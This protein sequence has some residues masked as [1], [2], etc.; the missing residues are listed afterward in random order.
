MLQY[1]GYCPHSL[2]QNEAYL[3]GVVPIEEMSNK[4]IIIFGAGAYGVYAANLLRD[5]GI[6]VKAFCSNYKT[7][8]GKLHHSI[9]IIKP[10]DAFKM[11]NAYFIVAAISGCET[12]QRQLLSKN[13]YDFSVFFL[14]S[15]GNISNPI[16]AETIR[17]SLIPTVMSK[18]FTEGRNPSQVS[19][20]DYHKAVSRQFKS[21]RYSEIV[22]NKYVSDFLQIHNPKKMLDIG[23]GNGLSSYV[24]CYLCENLDTAWICLS[25]GEKHMEE[26]FIDATGSKFP[27]RKYF[28]QIENPNFLLDEKF[29]LIIFTEIMEHL[30]C[31]PVPTVK[32]IAE[33]LSDDGYI[34]F[35]TPEEHLNNYD[36]YVEMPNYESLEK[37]ERMTEFGAPV[38]MDLSFPHTYIYS[39]Q[40]LEEIFGEAGLE[41]KFYHQ[42]APFQ[43]QHIILGKI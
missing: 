27:V 13:I 8:W 33:M 6:F 7:E 40:E 18:F 15:I 3:L 16:L 43:P 5:H 20:M 26:G 29:D 21:L 24:L 25:N 34:I 9:E 42:T 31:N 14:D 4:N 1:L 22:L 36:S 2:N 41:I 39:K 10:T 28:G 35:S 38:Y 17:Y 30:Q 37:Y 32:K 19:I 12:F 11:E 23:P